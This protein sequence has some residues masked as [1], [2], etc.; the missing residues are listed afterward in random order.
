MRVA[1]IT[2]AGGV[3]S[4]AGLLA[5]PMS[6]GADTAQAGYGSAKASSLTLTVSPQA[7]LAISGLD[8]LPQDDLG[9]V[10]T[11]KGAVQGD[12]S[13]SLDLSTADGV[14]NAARTDLVSGKAE[15]RPVSITLAGLD[16]VVG[17]LQALLE[18]LAGQGTLPPSLQPLQPVMSQLTA[19]QPLVAAIVQQLNTV[20]GPLQQSVAINQQLLANLP[21]PQSPNGISKTGNGVNLSFPNLQLAPYTATAVNNAGANGTGWHFTSAQS[22][23][24][25]TTTHL[26]ILPALDL[27][28]ID[29]AQLIKQITD[30]VTALSSVVT[31]VSQ[32]ACTLLGGLPVP[33]LGALTGPVCQQLGAGTIT[34]PQLS[35]ALQLQLGALNGLKDMLVGALQPLLNVTKLNGLIS[36]DGVSSSA[37]TKPLNNGVQTSATTS[38][39]DISLL[40]VVGNQLGLGQ[41]VVSIKGV[42][43]LVEA[44]VNGTDPALPTGSAKLAEVDVLGTPIDLNSLPVGGSTTIPVDTPV[45]SLT[46]LLSRGALQYINDTPTQ[47]SATN[48]TASISALEVQVL[49]GKPD[50]TNPLQIMGAA[51]PGKILDAAIGQSAVDAASTGTPPA[52]QQSDQ[53][54]PG[55]TVDCS[56]PTTGIFGTVGFAVGGALLLVAAAIRL[57]PAIR[58][59]RGAIG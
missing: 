24:H 1:R 34:P 59:R 43:S 28:K 53:S 40:Q 17:N 4:I 20:L 51:G 29:P 23:A 56:A 3:L 36:T 57:V 48:K 49:N 41:P 18:A 33:G 38:F 25:S 14:L 42:Q 35:S 8:K 54:N 11:L 37:L 21:D 50:G 44:F 5:L 13:V 22:E 39:A 52:P 12:T 31:N 32:P 27:S 47:P 9:L 30:L 10:S 19:V 26:S 16:K 6:A 46:V 58:S 2:A 15:S 7:L 55:C 45:G